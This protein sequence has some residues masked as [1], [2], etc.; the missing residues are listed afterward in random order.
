MSSSFPLM[1]R[2]PTNDR[3]SRE[4]NYPL[5]VFTDSSDIAPGRPQNSPK[6]REMRQ[7]KVVSEGGLQV[8]FIFVVSEEEQAEKSRNRL[9]ALKIKLFWG[10]TGSPWRSWDLNFPTRWTK[11]KPLQP[12]RREP[13]LRTKL[14]FPSSFPAQPQEGK[15]LHDMSQCME[16]TFSFNCSAC[17]QSNNEVLQGHTEDGVVLSHDTALFLQK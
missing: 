7:M 4:Q 17:H 15:Y 12:R 6:C 16:F 11:F 14:S 3:K 8:I 10:T 2:F 13:P 9:M 5:P 1:R